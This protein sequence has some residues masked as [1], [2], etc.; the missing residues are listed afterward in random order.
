MLFRSTAKATDDITHKINTIQGDTKNAVSSIAGISQAVEK[1]NGIS[2]V[3]AAAV[4]EQTATTNEISRVVVESKK[5][6]E[7]IAGTIKIVSQ[8][9]RESST[10]SSQTLD[11]SK[12]LGQLAEKLSALV[13]SNK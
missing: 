9:A 10:S 1:L 4:E 3:I 6:V 2:G 8:A 5:G 11:A 7:S 13:K 12:E